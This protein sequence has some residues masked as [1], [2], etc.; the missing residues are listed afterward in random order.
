MALRYSLIGFA[1][2]VSLL[3]A[4][5]SNA[6]TIQFNF[7]GTV[8][9]V[10]ST[11]ATFASTFNTSQTMTGFFTFESD[12]TDAHADP[13]YGIYALTSFS[14]SVGS[15]T[16]VG[17]SSQLAIVNEDAPYAD[18]YQPF[19]QTLA[20]PMVG[21]LSPLNFQI[22]LSDPTRAAFSSDALML[23]APTLA[24]F[25]TA[26][27][28]FHF[29]GPTFQKSGSLSGTI[30]SLTLAPAQVPDTTST[31]GLLAVTLVALA[32]GARAVL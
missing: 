22:N 16:S 17:T 5:P 10:Q 15:H 8:D 4:D 23:T 29:S 7:T 1:C 31:L 9:S 21:V 2:F 11:E 19:A 13:K 12:A 18:V 30:T 6:N 32:L 3:V 24:L 25:N 20:G 28:V 14:I 27:W 26:S